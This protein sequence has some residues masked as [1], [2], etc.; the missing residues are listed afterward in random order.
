MQKELCQC[1]SCESIFYLP[2]NE[3]NEDCP[4]CYSSNW[5]YGYIDDVPKQYPLKIKKLIA[6]FLKFIG[7]KPYFSTGIDEKLTGGYGELDEN[8]Y[9][10]YPLDVKEGE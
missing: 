4:F 1:G 2:V 10:E 8:G 6:K 7:I 9:F 5:V 3:R